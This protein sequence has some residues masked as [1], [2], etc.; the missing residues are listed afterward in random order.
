MAKQKQA[1]ASILAL[2]F[3]AASQMACKPQDL[4]K[5]VTA[6]EAGRDIA[7]AALPYFEAERDK[8]IAACSGDAECERKVRDAYRP[9]AEAYD[10]FHAAWCAVSP[11]SEGCE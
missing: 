4:E 5:I 10:A 1:A 6:A 11:D 9:I 3:L 8:M 7:T 2:C